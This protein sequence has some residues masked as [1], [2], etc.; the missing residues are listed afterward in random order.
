LQFVLYATVILHVAGA[1]Q[2]HF[3][4]AAPHA[5]VGRAAA[6]AA[7]LASCAFL[8]SAPNQ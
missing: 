1:L 6:G 3:V 5:V 8:L 4:H 7:V 2:H